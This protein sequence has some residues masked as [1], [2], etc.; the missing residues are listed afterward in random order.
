MPSLIPAVSTSGLCKSYAGAT[1][2]HP[3]SLDVPKGE[4]FGFLGHNGARMTTTIRLL[5]TLLAPTSGTAR[6]AGHDIG[7][8]P[9]KVRAATGYLP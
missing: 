6:I 9:L 4:V 2:L 7:T 5:I 3:L 1:M 8:D